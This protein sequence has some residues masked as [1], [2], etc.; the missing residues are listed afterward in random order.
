MLEE[1]FCEKKTTIDEEHD[2][3]LYPPSR[4]CPLNN[5]ERIWKLAASIIV[6]KLKMDTSFDGLS[7]EGKN[8][9]TA[10]VVSPS[11]KT[12]NEI[13][14]LEHKETENENKIAQLQPTCIKAAMVGHLLP[15]MLRNSPERI[16]PRYVTKPAQLPQARSRSVERLSTERPSKRLQ[17]MTPSYVYKYKLLQGNNGR[18][19]LGALRKRPWWH[20][21]SKVDAATTDYDQND[22]L[23]SFIWEMYRNPKRYKDAS[24]V[25]VML[26]HLEHNNGLVTK[27]GLYLTLKAYCDANKDYNLLDVVP[28]TYYLPSGQVDLQNGDMKE[29]LEFNR[30]ALAEQAASSRTN[31]KISAVPQSVV[32]P[33]PAPS[34]SSSSS[35]IDD[36]T[37]LPSSESKDV[38]VTENNIP[39]TEPAEVSEGNK[40]NVSLPSLLESEKSENISSII[41][42]DINNAPE[43]NTAAAAAKTAAPSSSTTVVG[44]KQD[45]HLG[46]VTNVLDDC[47]APKDAAN[48]LVWILKPGR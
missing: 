2:N 27:K 37:L 6:L 31:T 11:T 39:S 17:G 1:A 20:A 21:T 16:N 4:L 48:G 5:E 12:N 46:C 28:R 18:V 38:T 32:V 19:L 41:N 10:V 33:D 35:A 47:S 13:G 15:R 7:I 29:F 9:E 22:E 42:T 45:E 25:D 34:L 36:S 8:K 14:T 40:D 3:K 44:K 43:T 24:Y 23:P 26:N 30:Q